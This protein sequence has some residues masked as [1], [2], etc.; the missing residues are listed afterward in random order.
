MKNEDTS[1]TESKMAYTK[2]RKKQITIRIDEGVINYFKAMAAE[3][4][5]SYQ[6][7]INLYL[8]DCIVQKRQLNIS[9]S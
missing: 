7:L 8:T 1:L 6:N 4:G 9:F 5:M 2:K 3:T